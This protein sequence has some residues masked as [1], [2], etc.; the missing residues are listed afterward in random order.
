[1]KRLF[2]VCPVQLQVQFAVLGAILHEDIDKLRQ[3]ISVAFVKDCRLD[4]RLRARGCRLQAIQLNRVVVQSC[5]EIR[6]LVHT[7]HL[8]RNRVGSVVQISPGKLNR[9]I[10]RH[11][12]RLK[13]VVHAAQNR[14]QLRRKIEDPAPAVDRH[15]DGRHRA[16]SEHEGKMQPILRRRLTLVSRTESCVAPQQPP[17]SFLRLTEDAGCVPYQSFAGS[18]FPTTNVTG[19]LGLS[20]AKSKRRAIERSNLKYLASRTFRLRSQQEDDSKPSN[21]CSA[22]A[23]IP[24]KKRTSTTPVKI[25]KIHGRVQVFAQSCGSSRSREIR[26]GD[27]MGRNKSLSI[28]RNRLHFS[29]Q[30]VAT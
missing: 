20:A 1:M 16:I 30:F 28:I 25:R 13:L 8:E 22:R 12:R 9:D 21:T 24:G 4:G 10:C 23:G 27:A 7:K 19:V 15:C 26:C 2:V 3:L 6:G 29:R 5:R 18:L 17:H 11:I 14:V